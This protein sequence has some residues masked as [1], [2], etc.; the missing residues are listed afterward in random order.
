MKKIVLI[1]CVSKKG[2][3]KT[4]AKNLYK[5]P[6]FIKSLAYGQKLNPDKIY[7]LSALHHLLDLDTEIEPYNLT[8]NKMTKSEKENWGKKVI[9]QLQQVSDIKKDTF[10]VL[11]GQNYLTPIQNS[12]TNIETP[13]NRKKIGERLQYLTNQL[14]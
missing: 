14:K 4:R 8:L 11:A 5:S 6:L 13:L 3:N 1:S 9:E 10:I 12:L 7:I 2:N